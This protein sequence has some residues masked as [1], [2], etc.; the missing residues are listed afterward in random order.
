MV[1]VLVLAALFWSAVTA[2]VADE[3]P[4]N[5]IAV[6]GEAQLLLPPDYALIELGV[7]TQ[8]AMVSPALSENS[9]RMTR[10]IAASK[11]LG[12]QDKDIQTSTFLIQPKYEKQ[13]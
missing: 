8:G 9:D 11:A 5:T 13:E 12:I 4:R 10:V 2:A 3:T 7:V 6:A 1:R